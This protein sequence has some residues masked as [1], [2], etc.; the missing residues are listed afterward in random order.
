MDIS[1]LY[2]CSDGYLKR[3][4]ISLFWGLW[5]AAASGGFCPRLYREAVVLHHSALSELLTYAVVAAPAATAGGSRSLA[6]YR[7]PKMAACH[8]LLLLVSPVVDAAECECP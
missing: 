2:L 6:P 1:R 3:V 7:P 4:I 5:V 8:V